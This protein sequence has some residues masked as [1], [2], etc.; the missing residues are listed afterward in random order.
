MDL[1]RVNHRYAIHAVRCGGGGG[2]A[3]EYSI[4]GDLARSPGRDRRDDVRRDH[5]RGAAWAEYPATRAWGLDDRGPVPR[6]PRM[7][8]V[9]A[10]APGRSLDRQIS[11]SQKATF[12]TSSLCTAERARGVES[13]IASPAEPK[14]RAGILS[15]RPDV[16]RSDREIQTV[17]PPFRRG[18]RAD[19]ACRADSLSAPASRLARDHRGPGRRAIGVWR[20]GE[21]MVRARTAAGGT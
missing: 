4:R 14:A 19:G 15:A 7:Y 6:M 10:A 21:S 20:A 17:Y 2:D 13:Q 9:R 8:R 1:F 3:S 16:V 11:R 5:V 12:P 18:P